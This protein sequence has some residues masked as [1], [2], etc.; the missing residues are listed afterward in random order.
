M[1]RLKTRTVN[2]FLRVGNQT[3]QTP[4]EII[5]TCIG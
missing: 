2:N 5:D 3:A 1:I 4:A